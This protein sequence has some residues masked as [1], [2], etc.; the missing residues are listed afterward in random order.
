MTQTVDSLV[1]IVAAG[2]G[3]IIDCAGFTQDNL[4][5]IAGATKIK[6]AKITLI[7]TTSLTVDSIVR[8]ASV[9]E[10]NVVFDMARDSNAVS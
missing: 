8:I 9:G 2:G 7:N 3:L 4:V 1:R 6:N 10:G 5:R